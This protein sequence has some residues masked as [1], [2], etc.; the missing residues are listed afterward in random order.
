M[1]EVNSKCLEK[2]L[3]QENKRNKK[4]KTVNIFFNLYAIIYIPSSAQNKSVTFPPATPQY[5]L[6]YLSAKICLLEFGFF[7]SYSVL[8]IK[9]I[10]VTSSK[11]CRERW[12]KESDRSLKKRIQEAD[13]P[14]YDRAGPSLDTVEY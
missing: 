5:L 9:A 1:T 2:Q 4:K 6:L 13:L 10:I 14:S 12:Q 3:N 8:L 11:G 7:L